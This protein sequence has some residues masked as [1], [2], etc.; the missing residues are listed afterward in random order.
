[1]PTHYV[2]H[3]SPPPD[4]ELGL[5][6]SA[7]LRYDVAWP[8]NSSATPSDLTLEQST[9]G[10]ANGSRGRDRAPGLL[11]LIPGFGQ[12]NDDGYLHAFR[13]WAAE[14]FGLACMTVRYHG[15]LNRPAQ[16]ATRQ[17]AQPD[18]IRLGQCCLHYGVPWP[19]PP[20]TPNLMQ[21]LGQVEAAHNQRVAEAKARGEPSDILVLTCG[22]CCPD[23]PINLGL[24]QALDHLAA[25]HDLT[26]RH[27]Y[28]PANVIALGSSHGGYLAG[29]INKLAPHTLRAVLD[30]SGYADPPPRYIDSRSAQ[31]GPD[32]IENHSASFRFAYHTQS[33]WTHEA[34]QPHTYHADAHALRNLAHVPHLATSF[35]DAQRPAVFRCLHAPDDKIAATEEKRGFIA[36]LQ[37]HGL[38]ATLRVVTPADVDGRTIKSLDHGLG[39]SLRHFFETQFD[40]LPP[41]TAPHSND[42]ERQTTLRFNGEQHT[43]TVQHQPGRVEVSQT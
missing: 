22:L 11:L 37:N 27:R 1:M 4:V 34:G 28:D 17:F 3:C 19:D 31:V 20:A 18:V 16:G 12:D 13:H 43:L 35:A 33:A 24:P 26:R 2:Y 5:D 9:S 40:T 21:L 29:L 7:P 23:G 15:S 42:A 25:L 6:R 36:A 30:N 38:D 39:L 41:L 14:R 8:D 10:N 32:F